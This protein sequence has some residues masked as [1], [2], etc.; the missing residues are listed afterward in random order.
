MSFWRK[1]GKVI[2]VV[3]AVAAVVFAGPAIAAQRAAIHSSWRRAL[4]SRR[5]PGGWPPRRNQL[6]A[7]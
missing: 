1:L 3:V 6:Q 4:S 5:G 2:G 7:W